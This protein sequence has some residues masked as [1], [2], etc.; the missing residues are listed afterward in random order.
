MALK[1][2]QFLVGQPKRAPKSSTGINKTPG[3]L[4]ATGR[5]NA[6]PSVIKPAGRSGGKIPSVKKWSIN[7]SGK[8]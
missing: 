6:G 5:R 8:P 7:T 4:T 1:K 2:E 3:T